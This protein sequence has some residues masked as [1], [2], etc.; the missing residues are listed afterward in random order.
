[1]HCSISLYAASNEHF[2]SFKCFAAFVLSRTIN[3]PYSNVRRVW[4]LYLILLGLMYRLMLCY[5]A[6]CN[7]F[8]AIIQQCISI[9]FL[10]E[11]FSFSVSEDS[12]LVWTLCNVS[13]P[14]SLLILQWSSDLYIIV[15]TRYF[16]YI[17]FMQ[18][19]VFHFCIIQ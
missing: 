11:I 3:I 1:M 4:Q 16:I 19:H 6:I 5:I 7:P 2:F 8:L 14:V 12:E 15:Y 17:I 13:D 10:V 18:I 9:K